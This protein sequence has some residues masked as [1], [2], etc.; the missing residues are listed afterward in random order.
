ME[1]TTDVSQ[2]TVFAS[3][4]IIKATM[5]VLKPELDLRPGT[6]LADLLVNPG[7]IIHGIVAE[8]IKVLKE[9]LSIINAPTA[10][11]PDMDII[12]ELLANMLI[13]LRQGEH[14]SGK[15]RLNLYGS[16]RFYLP[17]T[18]VLL[19]APY[20]YQI[21]QAYEVL[22]QGTEPTAGVA[23][24]YI[25]EDARGY[26]CVLPFTAQEVGIEYNLEA[27][28][29][30]FFST[31]TDT[32]SES[33][34][35][36]VAFTGGSNPETLEE[37]NT[38][39][40]DMLSNNTFTTPA[41]ITRTLMTTY[42]NIYSVSPVGMGFIEQSRGRHNLFNVDVGG[43]VD[44]YVRPYRNPEV[45]SILVTAEKYDDNGKY[46]FTVTADDLDG[47]YRI[48]AVNSI[49][50]VNTQDS[51]S[52]LLLGSYPFE[53]KFITHGIAD[54]RHDFSSDAEQLIMETAYTKWSGMDVIIGPVNPIYDSNGGLT[55]PDT[56]TVDVEYYTIP[57]L[58]TIQ[59]YM[60]SRTSESDLIVRGGIPIFISF[61]A[62]MYLAPGVTVD[63]EA[64]KQ[65]LADYINSKNIGEA[66][67]ISELS[68]V[69]HEYNI[70]RIEFTAHESVN[71]IS[72]TVV[73][74]DSVIHDIIDD[75]INPETIA[76]L[77]TYF[78]ENTAYVAADTR[79]LFVAERRV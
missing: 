16:T 14:A 69:A 47:I 28:D 30:L 42:D 67:S 66:L 12:E 63:H 5:Q 19:A 31:G 6:S 64:V 15:V 21:D 77:S 76:G 73:D 70:Q 27:G 34:E 3:E 38:R 37:V 22:P 36:Y 18:Y 65:A 8:N 49:D 13:Q 4:E 62:Y 26:Y 41:G 55:Y 54:A 43:R 45:S 17:A 68:S 1:Y 71:F 25:D 59:D 79:D 33:A 32:Y 74:V 29:A 20:V 23:H 72:G 10:E 57:K 60:D 58:G 46:S 9:S 52:G 51:G 48:R 24:T 75:T 56:I 2:E 7:G 78:S 35:V 39:L 50:S 44:A 61:T 11:N 53:F 40:P